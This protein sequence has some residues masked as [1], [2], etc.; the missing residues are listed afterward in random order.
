MTFGSWLV[1]R[2][3][4]K[5]GERR[6]WRCLCRECDREYDIAQCELVH[7]HTSRCHHCGL[8][9]K[10]KHGKSRGSKGYQIWAAMRGRCFNPNDLDYPRWGGR[11]I[12]VCERWSDPVAFLADMG[13]P[14]PGALL[15]RIDNNG[16]Y[17]PGNCRWATL[18][19]S[20]RNRRSTR[21]NSE[22][23]KVMRFLHTRRAVSVCLLAR[24]H[25]VSQGCAFGVTQRKTW[26]EI[27]AA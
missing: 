8:A 6:R 20:N 5:K 17:E 13:E 9:R 7:G 16:N 21:L 14:P 25:G 23:V 22:I 10:R 1:L 15:D 2:E 4:T 19:E 26:R 11:G 12:T 3:T 24:L 18:T 27:N